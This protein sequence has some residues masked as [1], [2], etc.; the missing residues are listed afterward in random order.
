ME[1]GKPPGTATRVKAAGSGA[2]A[3]ILADA[4][5]TLMTVHGVVRLPAWDLAVGA[6][7]V[8]LAREWGVGLEL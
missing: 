8:A 7:A 3:C 5:P 4:L 6:R 2:E 1:P